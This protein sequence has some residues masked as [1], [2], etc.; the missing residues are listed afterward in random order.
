M[1]EYHIYK[2]CEYTDEMVEAPRWIIVYAE[3]PGRTL[4]GLRKHLERC[5]IEYRHCWPDWAYENGHL[6]KSMI[7]ELIHRM[8]EAARVGTP[9]C[10][11]RSDAAN[12]IPCIDSA[13]CKEHK[14][15][16]ALN[17]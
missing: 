9:P 17:K 14:L 15:C 11:E 16:K 12:R 5:G 13:W 10:G 6:N 1:A 8:M 2:N 4:Q 3:T 7:A